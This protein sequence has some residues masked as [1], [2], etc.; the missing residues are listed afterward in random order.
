MFEVVDNYVY[1]DKLYILTIRFSFS[2]AI[3]TI[4]VRVVFTHI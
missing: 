2:R 3:P 4:G 1:I